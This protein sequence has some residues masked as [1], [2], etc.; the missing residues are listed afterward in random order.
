[1]KKVLLPHEQR[2]QTECVFP[3]ASK[4]TQVVVI[5]LVRAG[6]PILPFADNIILTVVINIHE[7]Q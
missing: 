1:M 2:L 4:R 3:A 6:W 7:A 5:C